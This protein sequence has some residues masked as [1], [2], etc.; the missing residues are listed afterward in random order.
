M[1][2]CYKFP[3]NSSFKKNSSVFLRSLQIVV[4][5][6]SSVTATLYCMVC[7]QPS[8]LSTAPVMDT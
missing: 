6:E 5:T 4:Y 2:L 8:Y 1:G 3:S 7:P